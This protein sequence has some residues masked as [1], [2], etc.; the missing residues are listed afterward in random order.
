M[1]LL[2]TNEVMDLLKVRRNT[3]YKL[4]EAG[5]PYIKLGRSVRYDQ[6]DVIA[7]VHQQ[8]TQD[9]VSSAQQMAS[10]HSANSV[11][12]ANSET[13]STSPYL[14]KPESLEEKTM[15][16]SLPLRRP[17]DDAVYIL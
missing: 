6:D 13:I 1:N 12:A 11:H 2:T 5:L 9:T 3:V 7:W 14:K 4:R 17:I 10:V 8:K 15:P 16:P